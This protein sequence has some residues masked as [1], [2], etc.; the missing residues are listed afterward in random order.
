MLR[1]SKKMQRNRSYTLEFAELLA[2]PALLLMG[3]SAEMTRAHK[4]D[5]WRRSATELASNIMII[6]ASAAKLHAS[7]VQVIVNSAL[8]LEAEQDTMRR[9]VAYLNSA[10]DSADL[11][12]QL[13]PPNIAKRVRMWK[14]A[15]DGAQELIR[16]QTA[17]RAH[18]PFSFAPIPQ[19]AP[20]KP[21]PSVLPGVFSFARPPPAPTEPAP[22]VLPGPFSFIQR[23]P[24]K[25]EFDSPRRSVTRSNE[26]RKKYENLIE[27]LPDPAKHCLEPS[28][29]FPELLSAYDCDF[30][31]WFIAEKFLGAGSMGHVLKVFLRHPREMGVPD[32]VTT[33]TP[34]ALKLQTFHRGDYPREP[35]NE[36]A[37]QIAIEESEIDTTNVIKMF[38][39]ARWAFANMRTALNLLLEKDPGYAKLFSDDSLNYLVS[40]LEYAPYGTVYNTMVPLITKEFSLVTETLA[41]RVARVEAYHAIMLAQLFSQ[42]QN[43]RC[44]IKD[45]WHDDLHVANILVSDSPVVRGRPASSIVY[46]IAGT[47]LVV[48]LLVVNG[49]YTVLKIADFGY[50][51]GTYTDNQGRKHMLGIFLD[52]EVLMDHRALITSF[53]ALFSKIDAEAYNAFNETAVG[54]EIVRI[55]EITDENV[56]TD[57]NFYHNL[58]AN[59]EMFRMLRGSRDTVAKTIAELTHRPQPPPDTFHVV[60]VG[61]RVRRINKI[62][63]RI[64]SVQSN[65]RQSFALCHVPM[66]CCLCGSEVAFTTETG[67]SFCTFCMYDRRK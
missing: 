2:Q 50:A 36:I 29:V 10:I 65:L 21:A 67:S 5:V 18:I 30:A 51:R 33:A 58:L 53:R 20:I 45:F 34:L 56:T 9:E 52:K 59:N 15:F 39:W 60:E 11:D 8:D 35:M 16:E 42:L 22:F 66:G 49:V 44:V 12:A 27:K 40:V 32:Y 31:F 25:E 17:S 43:I 1:I 41:V 48:P 47:E 4:S 54:Q 37:V 6:E 23:P 38:F 26:M 57:L 7:A 63:S 46:K 3:L 55:F 28:K 19:P 62:E 64:D 13:L 14:V 24:S 61:N